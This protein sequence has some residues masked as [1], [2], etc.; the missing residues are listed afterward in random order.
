MSQNFKMLFFLKKGK[1]SSRPALPIYVRITI[2]GRRAEWS[3]QRSCE[4]S[5]W[6]QVAGKMSGTKQEAIELNAFLDAVRTSIFDLQKE[7]TLKNLPLTADGAR[8]KL[9]HVKD[10]KQ[11][12]LISVYE[13]HNDQFRE[14]VGK[15]FSEGTYKKFRSALVSIRNFISWKF[16]RED[17]FLTELDHVFITDYEFYLKTQQCM[18]H[19]SAMNNL[20]KL[21][22]I[23]RQCVAN[24][25][26][27]ADPFTHYKMRFNKTNRNYLHK[28]E[29]ATLAD[30]KFFAQR[31]DQVKDIFLFSCYTGFSYSDVMKLTKNDISVGIDSEMWI[32]TTRT[33]TD[34]DSRVPLL[35]MAKKIL[36]KYKDHP[37]AVVSNRLLPQL[38]NQR[39]NS[40][41]KEI[42]DQCG[43]NKELTFHCARHTFATTV[44]LSNGVPIETVGKMLGHTSLRT[45]QQYARILDRKVSD[46]MKV[47]KEKLLATELSTNEKNKTNVALQ[48]KYI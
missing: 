38:S 19:N 10:S 46:D 44:T 47:L 23:I 7:Y 40:Y 36:E 6:N 9:L 30:K 12:S 41:L 32:F 28:D 14:L 42:S 48:K 20:K 25:W 37:C 16:K 2:D 4:R 31:L 29:L 1:G 26:L 5:R 39:L 3:V 8:K 21:R 43:F 11:H 45:T 17:I 35:P 18:Q 34:S 24:K 27:D 15:E 13:Y 33:K 22:K